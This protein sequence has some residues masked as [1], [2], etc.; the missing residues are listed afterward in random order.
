MDFKKAEVTP[1]RVSA[2]CMAGMA[3]LAMGAFCLLLAFGSLSNDINLVLATGSV[4]LIGILGAAVMQL[5]TPEPPEQYN[6]HK[7]QLDH[8]RGMAALE[9]EKIKAQSM[10]AQAT[11]DPS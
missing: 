11:N 3:F 4:G 2:I 6:A 8:E 9:V 7:A 1:F 5:I 10:L